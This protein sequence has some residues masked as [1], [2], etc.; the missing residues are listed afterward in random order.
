LQISVKNIC[1][2]QKNS[3]IFAL[4]N[5]SFVISCPTSPLEKDYYDKVI[6]A[7]IFPRQD[8]TQ[9]KIC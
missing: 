3:S 1:Q 8:N 7:L 4:Q 2:Y 5:V 9:S 6:F